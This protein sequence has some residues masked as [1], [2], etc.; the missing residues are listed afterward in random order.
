MVGSLWRS[1]H[2]ALRE[3][4]LD[5]GLDV[6]GDDIEFDAL[7]RIVHR[8]SDCS[9]VAVP[10]HG[11]PDEGAH[12]VQGDEFPSLGVDQDDPIANPVVDDTL[13]RLRLP[14]RHVDRQELP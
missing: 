10:V 14:A 3:E 13:S 9:D 2:Q 7:D 8:R 6:T 11:L 1:G 5:E 12:R 4:F